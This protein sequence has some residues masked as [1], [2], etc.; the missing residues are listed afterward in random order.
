MIFIEIQADLFHGQFGDI[1]GLNAQFFVTKLHRDSE[2]NIFVW[3]FRGTL[4][5]RTLNLLHRTR[6]ECGLF[7]T[8]ILLGH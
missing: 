5:A 2:I 4:F 7:K 6:E 3:S 1:P 8:P